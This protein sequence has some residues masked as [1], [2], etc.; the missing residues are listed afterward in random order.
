MKIF[1]KLEQS[2]LI[3]F[4]SSGFVGDGKRSS[5]WVLTSSQNELRWMISFRIFEIF[6]LVCIAY[7]SIYSSFQMRL[8]FRTRVGCLS[9]LSHSRTLSA[10]AV[11]ASIIEPSAKNIDKAASILKAG[12]LVS[13]PTETVYGL[14]ANAF[15]VKA[16]QSIFIAKQRPY[17]DPLIVHIAQLDMM[18]ELFD[19]SGSSL[20]QKDARSLCKAL[21]REFWPGPFTLIYKANPDLPKEVSAGTGFV[22]LR[23]PNHPIALKLIEASGTPIAAPSAVRCTLVL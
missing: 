17:T 11:R 23:C 6:R 18:D 2:F 4:I 9:G 21:A 16:V 8:M 14:G 15:D 10:A 5:T 20:E 13:F 7:F 22:G 12:G 19:F 1:E 3:I